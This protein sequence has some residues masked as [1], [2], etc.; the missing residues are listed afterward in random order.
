MEVIYEIVEYKIAIQIWKIASPVLLVFGTAGNLL[1][2]IVLMQRRNRHSATSLYLTALALSDLLVLWTGLLRRWLIYLFAIDLRDFTQFGC[3]FHYF[4][5]YVSF[6]CSSWFLVG[7]TMD[8]F[9]SV[10]LPHKVK[11]ICSPTKAGIIVIS[12]TTLLCLLNLHWFY[13]YTLVFYPVTNTTGISSCESN[14]ENS[15]LSFLETW[16]WLDLFIVSLIPITI[17]TFANIAIITRLAI[18]KHKNRF[19]VAPNSGQATR[20][21]EKTS[22][23][24]TMLITVNIMFIICSTP[25]SVFFIVQQRWYQSIQTAHELAVFLL[26]W[27]LVNML[28]YLNSTLNFALYFLSGNRFRQEVKDFFRRMR[29]AVGSYT[30]N[31]RTQTTSQTRQIDTVSTGVRN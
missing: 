13:G 3:K 6:Q 12:I 25:M 28:A 20:K 27:A 1:T 5:V 30:L 23:L 8:R 17:L 2:V 26:W 21:R 10:L 15:Y 24:T 9:I 16:Q 11:I 4:I 31:S 29:R 7:V 19:Q 14:K 18:R 22:Q